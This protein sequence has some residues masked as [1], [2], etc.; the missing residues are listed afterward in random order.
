MLEEDL[1]ARRIFIVFTQLVSSPKRTLIVR[2]GEDVQTWERIA[3][4]ALPVPLILAI[5]LANE[6]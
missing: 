1:P 5:D 3:T 2:L 4:A 6:L